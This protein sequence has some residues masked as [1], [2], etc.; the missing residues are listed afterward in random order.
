MKT[1]IR[2]ASW[3][4]GALV[5]RRYLVSGPLSPQDYA[6]CVAQAALYFP[7][8][9]YPYKALRDIIR[10]PRQSGLQTVLWTW[11]TGD[12]F[13][14]E[15]LCRSFLILG[16]IGSGKTS[17]S[18][19]MIARALLACRA[20]IIIFGSK[21]D[22]R[23]E[24]Q[25]WV[26]EAGRL[27]DWVVIAP[28]TDAKLNY[29]DEEVKAG[30][31][32]PGLVDKL[33]DASQITV[34]STKGGESAKFFEMSETSLL[35]SCIG[36]LRLARPTLKVAE[37][38]RMLSSAPMS[39]YCFRKV[40]GH[41]SEYDRYHKGFHFSMM[42][43]ARDAKKSK[44]DEHDFG[45]HSQFWSTTYCTQDS[46]TRS[47]IEAGVLNILDV[48]LR[49]VV[50]EKLATETNV[51]ASDL[52]RG[53]VIFVDF[54]PA[55][56]GASGK[57][58]NALLKRH[59]QDYCLR[60]V[61]KPGDRIIALWGDEAQAIVHE[62]DSYFLNQARSHGSAL[63]YLTQSISNLRNALGNDNAD[64][65][66]GQFGHLCVHACDPI[67]AQYMSD[68]VGKA[69]QVTVNTSEK[70][71]GVFEQ[72][73]GGGWNVSI[74]Q[75][76]RSLAESREFSILKTGGHA[77]KLMVEGWIV[78]TGSPFSGGLGNAIKVTFSQR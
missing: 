1:A 30:V 15:D 47:N 34:R 4:L 35:I 3:L 75:G 25:K 65:L 58:L 64:A 52:E 13:T 39:P 19:K 33:I 69:M 61:F 71:G 66:M 23:A 5:A 10:K 24:W 59:V 22:D 78:K 18:G 68:R 48:F 6:D 46:K 56:L 2:T 29:L 57:F 51:H 28:D 20:G 11:H 45:Q 8:V 55:A 53:A 44:I 73:T 62:R 77:N 27:S 63:V 67:T 49:G 37:I 36:P 9:Y 60:R 41:E 74:Q 16:A 38:R 26:S 76:V 42:A 54:S 17:S 70:E 21:P 7:L 31:D 32:T 43:A 40:E 12:H 14:I 72:L 50:H